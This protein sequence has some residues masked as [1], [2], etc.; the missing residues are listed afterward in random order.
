MGATTLVCVHT[1][2]I[3]TP[4][5]LPVIG[6]CTVHIRYPGSLPMYIT[7]RMGAP[8][9]L[10]GYLRICGG[11]G[12]NHKYR[13]VALLAGGD[14]F[15][16]DFT[17][18]ISLRRTFAGLRLCVAWTKGQASRRLI[19]RSPDRHGED[20]LRPFYIMECG[21]QPKCATI[22]ARLIVVHVH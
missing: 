11:G 5:H 18:C 19:H 16:H 4:T 21:R 2:R 14:G 15:E 20:W 17:C 13:S 8:F 9:V 6:W 3:R 1:L 7:Y 10:A 12:T 22:I